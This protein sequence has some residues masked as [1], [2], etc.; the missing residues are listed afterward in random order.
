MLLTV[1][2]LDGYKTVFYFVSFLQKREKYTTLD[3]VLS[4]VQ[5][6]FTWDKQEDKNGM[7]ATAVFLKSFCYLL[8]LD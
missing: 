4:Q 3:N 2:F 6:L 5:T 7:R 8:Q 1:A